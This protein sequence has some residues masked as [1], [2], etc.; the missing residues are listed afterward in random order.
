MT[1]SGGWYVTADAEQAKSTGGML[2][3]YPRDDYA[4]QLAIP[5]GEPPEDL[6]VTLFYFGED[7]TEMPGEA[8]LAQAASGIADQFSPIVAKVFG[9]AVFNPDGDDPCAVYLVGNS[10]D[11]GD[12]HFQ[13]QE[14]VAPYISQDQHAP[15]TPHVTAGYSTDPSALGYTGDIVFDRCVL[16]W[17]GSEQV[18]PFA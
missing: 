11:L 13:L 3:L 9:H 5:G 15:W 12:L 7:V 1:I 18:F 10:Q 4:Q 2:A 14:V 17:A 8:E 6:H 16:K